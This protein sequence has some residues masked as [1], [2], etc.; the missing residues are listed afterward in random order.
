MVHAPAVHDSILLAGTDYEVV[1]AWV[2]SSQDV[3]RLGHRAGELRAA[4]RGRH[5][6]GFYFLWSVAPSLRHLPQGLIVFMTHLLL[7]LADR[8]F[9]TGIDRVHDLALARSLC[10]AAFYRVCSKLS[11]PLVFLMQ[12]IVLVPR[13]L[14]VFIFCSGLWR[15]GM[16]VLCFRVVES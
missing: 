6:A 15:C 12:Q 4:M 8:P 10:S 14:D 1:T 5:L 3:E 9:T 2:G 11:W 16:Q 7:P 13:V